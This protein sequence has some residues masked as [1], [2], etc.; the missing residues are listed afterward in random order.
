MNINAAAQAL[1]K[2]QVLKDKVQQAK[3][4]LNDNDAWICQQEL[5]KIY[6]QVLIL[7]LEYALDKKVE[8]ELWNL[9][10]K[11]YIAILQAQVK[12]R[13]NVHRAESQA[14][15]SWCLEAASGFY[16]SL[17]QEICGAFNLDLAFR[18]KGDIYGLSSPWDAVQKVQKINKQSSRHRSSCFYVCQYC[19]V[20][21]G[22]IARYR[23][24]N[25]QAELFYRHAVSL[26]PWS[27]QPYNQL[28]LL[29]AS[30]VDK[31][32]TV[33]YYARSVAVKHPFHVATSNLAKTLLINDD[34]GCLSHCHYAKLSASEYTGIFLKLHGAIHHNQLKEI[35]VSNNDDDINAHKK[36]VSSNNGLKSAVE[37]KKLLTDSNFTG[38]I[39]TDGF[40]SWKLVQML[41]INLYAL[42]HVAGNSSFQELLKPDQLS[43][44]EQLARS[45]ILDLIAGSLSALLLP[46]YTLKTNIIDYFALSTIKLYLEWLMS[47]QNVQSLLEE[48]AFSSRLQIWPSLCALLNGLNKE[49]GDF[50]GDKFTKIPLPEDWELQGFLPLERSFEKLKFSDDEY[51]DGDDL[52][53]LRAVRILELG[54]LL[55]QYRVNGLNLI[56]I[57]PDS[58]E[59]EFIS[60]TNNSVNVKLLKE[61]KEFTLRK[62]LQEIADGAA[63]KKKEGV[64]LKSH[65][66]NHTQ[67]NVF[68][69]K[70]PAPL[71]RK[72]RQ[73]IAIQAIMKRAEMDQKPAANPESTPMTLDKSAGNNVNPVDNSVASAVDNPAESIPVASAA[74]D[75]AV[76]AD[77][78]AKPQVLDSYQVNLDPLPAHTLKNYAQSEPSYLPTYP[79]SETLLNMPLNISPYYVPNNTI[80]MPTSQF[81]GGINDEQINGCERVENNRMLS[82][83]DIESRMLAGKT[84]QCDKLEQDRL[85]FN[86][87][88]NI[89]YGLM[90][91]AEVEPRNFNMWNNP[92]NTA[93]NSWWSNAAPQTTKASNF[94]VN[95]YP[96]WSCPAPSG[97][98][99]PSMSNTH[100]PIISNEENVYSLFSE[101][102]WGSSGQNNFPN[103]S[104]L[105]NQQQ[106]QQRSLWSGPGP[107]PLER[108]LEQQK[109][110]RGE[111]KNTH[112]DKYM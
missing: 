44:D 86:Q 83:G 5:Q 1:R 14:M 109:S 47:Q 6:Q 106:H 51:L 59:G 92:Q 66:R 64:V 10:F 73:N 2:A 30:K 58:K 98:L 87:P 77:L 74:N 90:M 38:L 23:N 39:V 108:L 91:N 88:T 48:D 82:V 75:D 49:V 72:I 3:D 18:R 13:K 32:A 79:S 104:S 8:Q 69:K 16:Q 54:R 78:S 99:A 43:S 60:A 84:V 33:Y 112:D 28:A 103:Y 42:H 12:D 34:D 26:A 81:N 40:N 45:Y 105:N 21:L 24:E 36:D 17:L 41:V 94:D 46:V 7:D 19:L 50:Y 89:D 68:V 85:F 101:N 35:S 27:G 102:S 15:L 4:L 93:M 111:T 76:P 20:H 11:N 67:Q 22:D 57:S 55:T 56:S 96:S 37:Y 9:G 71:A 61:L 80:S 29:E 65:G 97:S 25:K 107:S 95:S 52:K 110:L 70:N 31:L 100:Q 63:D 62:E 53:K